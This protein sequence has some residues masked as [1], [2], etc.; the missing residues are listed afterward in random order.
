MTRST[1]SDD[2]EVQAQVC[3]FNNAFEELDLMFRWDAG[4][5]RSLAGAD[6]DHARIAHYVAMHRPHLLKVYSADFLCQAIVA[7]K[8]AALA[9]CR[10]NTVQYEDSSRHARLWRARE[11]DAQLAPAL[12]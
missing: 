10:A 12:A 4:I 5:Y 2:R 6:T 1:F 7:R 11:S 3:A 8:N 9:A